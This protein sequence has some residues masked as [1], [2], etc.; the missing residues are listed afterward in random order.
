M[1]KA[2]FK[3]KCKTSFHHL[4]HQ[5]RRILN[6]EFKSKEDL[7]HLIKQSFHQ[8]LINPETYSILENTI[9]LNHL[10]VR[11]IMMPKSQMVYI[12][13]NAD[14]ISIIA[15]ITQSG[16]SRFPVLS[17]HG[18]GILGVLHAKD[19]LRLHTDEYKDLNLN[20]LVRTANF[21]PESKPLD[22]LLSDFKK[23]RNHMALVVDEYGQM[24]GFVTLEDTIEQIIGD[25]ADEF[26]VDEED[27]IKFLSPKHLIIKGDT[28]IEVFNERLNAQLSEDQF[29]TVAGLVTMQFGYPPKRGE[30]IKIEHFKFK[31]ISA[32]ARHIKL[33]ECID[34]RQVDKLD[35]EDMK[36]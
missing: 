27:P 25:I 9:N 16:H 8:E 1:N 35:N 5:L 2:T 7:I 21:V 17:E 20:D 26:D 22:A 32:S 10:K 6:L 14:L 29:D 18:E 13:G 34:L 3:H 4:L 33:I 24:I 30:E 19:L 28:E 31:I 12:Q 36:L 15:L 23:N 11:D